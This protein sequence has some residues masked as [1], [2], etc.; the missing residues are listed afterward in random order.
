[1][2]KKIIIY[3]GII[4]T[5]ISKVLFEFL[6]VYVN[7]GDF[8]WCSVFVDN[9]SCSFAEWI[10]NIGDSIVML[11]VFVIGII[12]GIIFYKLKK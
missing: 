6:L 2:R 8:F 7:Q 5:I 1:M 12:A 4:P 9:D 10:F 3:W 11:P